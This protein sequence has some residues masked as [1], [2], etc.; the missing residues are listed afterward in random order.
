MQENTPP[1]LLYVFF[2]AM[3]QINFFIEKI[4]RLYNKSAYKDAF[5]I[6]IL[7]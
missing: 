1:Y 4:D 3:L 6:S 5:A 2:Q 7:F